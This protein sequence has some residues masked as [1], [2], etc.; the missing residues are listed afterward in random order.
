MT[1]DQ[2]LETLRRKRLQQM[3]M[4]Q[5]YEDAV[6]GQQEAAEVDMEARRGAALRQILEPDARDRLG[7]LRTAHP[8]LAAHAEDQLIAL[9]QSGR[10][11]R[12]VTDADLRR[13]LRRLAPTKREISITFK[14]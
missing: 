7:R 6:A 9:A 2:E 1:D 10:L 12:V 4:Q 11:D 8:E 14:K 5:Q 13:I 3:E